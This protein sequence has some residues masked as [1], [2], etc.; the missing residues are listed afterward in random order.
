MNCEWFIFEVA[1]FVAE[2]GFDCLGVEIGHV[3][4]FVS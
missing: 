1:D 2:D 3:D 4:C